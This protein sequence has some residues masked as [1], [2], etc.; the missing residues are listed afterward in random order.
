[1]SQRKTRA[2]SRDIPK[3]Q[4]MVREKWQLVHANIKLDQALHAFLT[5]TLDNCGVTIARVAFEL[6]HKVLNPKGYVRLDH[7]A[8]LENVGA[9]IRNTDSAWMQQGKNIGTRWDFT[10]SWWSKMK[11]WSSIDSY[12][13]LSLNAVDNFCN[14]SDLEPMLRTDN[15]KYTFTDDDLDKDHSLQKLDW[16]QRTVSVIEGLP[17]NSTDKAVTRW[18]TKCYDLPNKKTVELLKTKEFD[19]LLKKQKPLEPYWRLAQRISKWENTKQNNTQQQPDS[20]DPQQ[21]AQGGDVQGNEP[22]PIGDEQNDVQPHDDAEEEEDDPLAD[23]QAQQL[24]PALQMNLSLTGGDEGDFTLEQ[25][26]T[27]AGGPVTY[28]ILKEIKANEPSTDEGKEIA[29]R[30]NLPEWKAFLRANA[31]T[32]PRNDKGK[33]AN[34]PEVVKAVHLFLQGKTED[35]IDQLKLGGEQDTTAG[36]AK[37]QGKGPGKGKGKGAGG[38]GDGS[39]D[40]DGGASGPLV[41]KLRQEYGYWRKHRT[42]RLNDKADLVLKVG[43]FSEETGLYTQRI[44]FA[45]IDGHDKTARPSKPDNTDSIKLAEKL[46]SSTSVQAVLQPET[47]HIRSNLSEYLHDQIQK[48][49]LSTTTVELPDFQ[50]FIRSLQ[51]DTKR[52]NTSTTTDL[53]KF[54][55]AIHW[56]HHLF[57]A[58]VKI[59]FL[60]HMREM[61][62]IDMLCLDT[63]DARMQ[64]HYFFINFT[65]HHLPNELVFQDRI[66]GAPKEWLESKLMLL[67]RPK[68]KCSDGVTSKWSYAPV[69]NA[70]SRHALVQNLL[71]KITKFL[72]Q[73]LLLKITKF[74]Q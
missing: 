33:D 73:N 44:V 11:E 24:A 12:K 47:Y 62:G 46:I 45:E 23:V 53:L 22:H 37:G 54:Q 27:T 36:T 26:F 1:M 29:K 64:D 19:E 2:A 3:E 30:V 56:V 4:A 25:A 17:C 13:L 6:V 32:V 21:P 67:T 41:S 38:G 52:Q 61:H 8:E 51:N 66:P 55:E 42:C 43:Y 14:V 20:D 60:I 40:G 48:S 49:L 57:L 69:V 39:G 68:I 31:Q 7:K 58:H 15:A 10:E 18:E 9:L 34:K 74:L 65:G 71:L 72:V 16:T 50:D 28:D 63:R 5:Q 70:S 35:E 59:A